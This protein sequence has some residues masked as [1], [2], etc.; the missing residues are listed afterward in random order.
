MGSGLQTG[1]RSA[2]RVNAAVSVVLCTRHVVQTCTLGLTYNR[3]GVCIGPGILATPPVRASGLELVPVPVD[4]SGLSIE[5]LLRLKVGAVYVT[6]AHQFPTG[7]VLAAARRTAL[8][9]W[10]E[11]RDAFVLEDDYD[12]DK[13]LRI[14]A[15]HSVTRDSDSNAKIAI[16]L[17]RSASYSFALRIVALLHQ[18]QKC[19]Q[20]HLK[21]VSRCEHASLAKGL[22]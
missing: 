4:D 19:T 3:K 14:D 6:P 22:F 13:P 15:C 10:A 18:I 11:K 17:W 12:G 21:T 16:G 2:L 20:A 9:A 7:T 8:L 1:R 5:H